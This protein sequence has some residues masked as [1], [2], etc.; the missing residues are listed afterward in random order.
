MVVYIILTWATV[1]QV[2]FSLL[3]AL[4]GDADGSCACSNSGAELVDGCCLMKACQ[5]KT[6]C[7]GFGNKISTFIINKHCQSKT[8]TK[9]KQCISLVFIVKEILS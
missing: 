8:K 6:K 1:F 2:A 4:S 9:C 3:C 5:P 7:K